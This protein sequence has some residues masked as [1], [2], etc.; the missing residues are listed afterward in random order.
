MTFL[1]AMRWPSSVYQ[2]LEADEEEGW[3]RKG[4]EREAS[5]PKIEAFQRIS[6]KL[7][8]SEKQ[9]QPQMLFNAF[10]FTLPLLAV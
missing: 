7:L 4:G 3:N 6:S 5:P 2:A 1:W 8:C 9:Q 10:L